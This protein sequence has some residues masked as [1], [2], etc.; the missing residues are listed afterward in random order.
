MTDI[1]LTTTN[2]LI[3]RDAD[4]IFYL[5]RE[6][7][8]FEPN[9]LDDGATPLATFD[10]AAAREIAAQ[11]ANAIAAHDK[12]NDYAAAMTRLSE[13]NEARR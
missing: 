3:E 4:G 6:R 1:T 7:E 5:S 13:W 10:I 11:L 8:P 12:A 9:W 2:A